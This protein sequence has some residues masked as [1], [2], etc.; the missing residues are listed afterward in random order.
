MHLCNVLVVVWVGYRLE[1]LADHGL[2]SLVLQEVLGG[3]ALGAWQHAVAPPLQDPNI[4]YHRQKCWQALVS[5]KL[6]DDWDR[7]YACCFV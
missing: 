1:S 3:A 2:H 5:V 7:P 4:A 6:L